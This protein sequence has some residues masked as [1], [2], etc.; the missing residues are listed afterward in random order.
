MQEEHEKQQSAAV[1]KHE[2]RI[3]QLEAERHELA[4]H[5]KETT[6]LLSKHSEGWK[7]EQAKTLSLMFSEFQFLDL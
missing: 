1:L 3:I 6:T 5:L 2:A 4:A 7:K